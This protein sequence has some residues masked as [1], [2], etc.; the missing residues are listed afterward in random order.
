MPSSDPVADDVH[1]TL[2]STSREALDRCPRGLVAW[3]TAVLAFRTFSRY[4]ARRHFLQTCFYFL[5]VQTVKRKR[6]QSIS[7][8]EAKEE[9]STPALSEDDMPAPPKRAV[10]PK[11]KG[12]GKAESKG[13]TGTTTASG[14]HEPIKRTTAASRKRAEKARR[15]ARAAERGGEYSSEEDL[16]VSTIPRG[17]APTRKATKRPAREVVSTSESDDSSKRR[18]KGGD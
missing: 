3:V 8:D 13:K 16:G 14:A 9:A 7:D 12:N 4:V 1:C 17:K 11:G 10:E 6:G 15:D 2:A 18:K 5:S